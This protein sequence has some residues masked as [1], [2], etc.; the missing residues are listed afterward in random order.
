ML[1]MSGGVGR[2]RAGGSPL[3]PL[4]LTPPRTDWRRVVLI[5]CLGLATAGIGIVAPW[6]GPLRPGESWES[7]LVQILAGLTMLGAGLI[8][9]TR[10]PANGIWRLMVA[11]YFA[12][13]IWELSFIPSYVFWTLYLLFANLGQAIFAHLLLA[14][15]S[16]R[17]RSSAERWLVAFLYAYAVGTPLLQMLFSKPPYVCPGYCPQNLL[18]VWPNNELADTIGRV[19]GLGVPFLAALVAILVWRHWRRASAP[20]R[21][22][23]QPVVVALPFA[24][25]SASVGYP[26]DSF[27]IA[28]ISALVRSP[29][30]LLT[31]FILPVA[32]LLGVLRLRATR[33][34]VASAVLE[35]GA[36]PTL[37]RLQEVLRT[38]L[39]DPK[40]EVLRWSAA[41]AAFIDQDGRASSPPAGDGNEALTVLE[42]DGEPAAAVL[43]DTAIAE[44]PALADTIRAAVRM[45]LDATELQDELRARGGQAGGLPTGEVTFLF[46]DIEGST[47]LLESLGAQYAA[48]LA[49]LRRIASE[50]ADRHGGRLVDAMGDEVFLVFQRAPDAVR[51][52]IELTARLAAM[53]WPRNASVRVRIGLHTGSPE[54]TRS[55]YVGLDVHRAA[56]IMALAHGGQIL[57]SEAT[58]AGFDRTGE[59]AIRALGRYALRG[60]SEPLA[61]VQIAEADRENDFPPPRGERVG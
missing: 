48:V 43:H 7:I 38:R 55:G 5:G 15:P 32:F 60:V 21:R 27:G 36:L 34:A 42:R 29:A 25:V 24:F 59:I 47:P 10:Q 17:L 37:T 16:G 58:V 18:V 6:V 50:I 41:Q 3:A 22:A 61:V 20:A 45:A 2:E 40:L 30:W 13:F 35:L 26:A 49:E 19:T 51:S 4:S 52:A 28:T 14:F 1:V 53:T 39:G 9:S 12:G 33:A 11:S 8:A 31:D 44:E 23:L 54:L 57:A 46:G 56:R